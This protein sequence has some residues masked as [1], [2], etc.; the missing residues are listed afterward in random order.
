MGSLC[1]IAVVE[2]SDAGET[3]LPIAPGRGHLEV[4]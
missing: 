4:H 3:R 2:D 1:L